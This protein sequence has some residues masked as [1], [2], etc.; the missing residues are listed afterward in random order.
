MSELARRYAA[1]L[2]AV[3][4]D[5]KTL[6]DTARAIMGNAPLWESLV[7]PPSRPGRR[8]GS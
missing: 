6:E 7:P 4:P 3:S 5:E 1:A 8:T 2:Y